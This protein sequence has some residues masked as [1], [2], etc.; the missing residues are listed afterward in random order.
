[1][2][3]KTVTVFGATGEAGVACVDELIRQ[4]VFDVCVLARKPGQAE[5]SS[6]GLHQGDAKKKKQYADWEKNGVTIKL[7]DATSCEDLIPALDGTDYLVSC[8]P[9]NATES[10]Y[11][12]IWACKE[13]GVERFVPSEFGFIYEFEQFLPT[14]TMHR[15]TARQKAFIRRVIEMAGLD[16]TIIPAGQWPEYYMLEPVA[17]MGDGENKVAWSSG[18]DAGRII[19]HVLAHPASRNAICPVAATA[20]CTWNELLAVREKVLGRKV[21]RHYLS[22]DQWRAAYAKQPPGAI[23]L[24]MAIGV[25]ATESPDGMQLWGNWNATYIPEFKGTPLEELFRTRIEPFVEVARQALTAAG[26]L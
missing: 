17:V 5:R 1:M 26:E 7:V 22:R 18:P 8:V 12:L 9:I 16:Y 6:S 21:E 13:A 4:K 20:Y 24:I 10:Q 2:A 25:A 3:K 14:D 19:P 15:A 23:K 11:P